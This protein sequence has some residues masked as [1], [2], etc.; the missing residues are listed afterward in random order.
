MDVT[1]IIDIVTE[2]IL[3]KISLPNDHLDFKYHGDTIAT[4][5]ILVQLISDK[6]KVNI[7]VN[8]LS[9]E[10]VTSLLHRSVDLYSDEDESDEIGYSD[11][12]SH[13]TNCVGF[14]KRLDP[15]D[16]VEGEVRVIYEESGYTDGTYYAKRFRHN[17]ILAD[18][19]YQASWN[20]KDADGLTFTFV[21]KIN[22]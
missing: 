1:K 22:E 8:N 13:L 14:D 21:A 19:D 3:D 20:I 16:L 18:V 5:D 17:N 6:K 15:R 12:S 4:T 7:K 11:N 9:D 2:L 10:V